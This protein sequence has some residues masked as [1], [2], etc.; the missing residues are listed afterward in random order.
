[1]RRA[2]LAAALLCS[3]G[4]AAGAAAA[5]PDGRGWEMVSPV[6][7]NGGQVEPPGPAPG[8][9]LTQA[10]PGGDAVTYSSAASFG[11]DPQGAPPLSQY[12]ARRSGAGWSSENVSPPLLSGAYEGNP[13]LAFSTDLSRALLVNP[14]RCP[15]GEPC[16]AGYR[17]KELASGALTASPPDPGEFE[18]ASPG[19]DHV[20]FLKGED[21][22]RW[23]PP[24]SG[25]TMLNSSPAAAL[26]GE[27]AVSAGGSRVYWLG[28]D[29]NLYLR[30]G[31]ATKQVDAAAGGGGAFAAASADGSL[32]FFL[33]AGHLWRYEAAS[34][35]AAEL[36]PGG[37]GAVLGASA[38]GSRL[39][40]LAGSR[41]HRWRPGGGSTQLSSTEISGAHPAS[42]S[43]SADGRRLLFTTTAPLV[44]GDT[45]NDPDAYQWQEQGSGSCTR[46]A[47]CLELI[48]SGRAEDGAALAAASADGNDAFFLTARSLVGADP[49]SVDLYDA[50]VGGGF[51]EPPPPIPCTGDSCQ[52][53]P[54]EPVD[55]TLTTLLAGLGNPRV[56]YRGSFRN[57]RT[58]ARAGKR[59]A[60]AARGG[61]PPP[62]PP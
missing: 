10:S 27:G 29:G 36:T 1:M 43:V 55:P 25:L 50:R 15:E 34:D 35:S 4:P 45:N 23:S 30:D 22:H 38:D 49:G 28:A 19:L 40:Y 7:K 8:G 42:S 9:A 37:V 61:P 12:V 54:S 31:G 33:A 24:A 21:L 5:L 56:R 6:D 46:S 47:G 51:P 60:R 32:A 52:P 18:G 2:A 13:Y 11:E 20:V 62:P 53:L 41:L 59:L 39:F 16:P 3:L 57:C 58:L 44:L 48:S 14:S 17:L 26:A